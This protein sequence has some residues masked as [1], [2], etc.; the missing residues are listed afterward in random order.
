MRIEGGVCGLLLAGGQ[1]RRMG[2]GDKCLQMLGGKTLLARVIDC[3]QPQVD[4]LVLN[5][6]GDLSRFEE[7]S[8]EVVGD[9][10]DGFAGPLAGILTGLEWVRDNRP[11][12]HWLA[13]FA[14]DAPFAPSDLVSRLSDAIE[15]NNGD[16]A[17]AS[18]NGRDQPVFGLWPVALAGDLRSALVNEDLRKV[19]VWTARYRLVHADWSVDPVDP[20]LNVNRPEDLATAAQVLSSRT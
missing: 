9:V 2:G 4:E 1:S 13:S 17:C 7:Y 5:A 15:D 19:D 8:L 14:C 12:C 16:L 18:S 6:N 20:F 10:V 3:A 11:N